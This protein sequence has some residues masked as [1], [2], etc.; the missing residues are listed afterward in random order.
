MAMMASRNTPV[1]SKNSS[2]KLRQF[3]PAS[4]SRCK[5]W[6]VAETPSR[7]KSSREARVDGDVAPDRRDLERRSRRLRNRSRRDDNHSDSETCFSHTD[8]RSADL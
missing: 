1:E 6:S 8:V 2:V 7:L 5:R 3:T 4:V